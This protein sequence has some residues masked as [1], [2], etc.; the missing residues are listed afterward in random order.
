[1]HVVRILKASKASK[2]S[3]KFK[4][5][6]VKVKYVTD[7]TITKSHLS[8]TNIRLSTEFKTISGPRQNKTTMK[9]PSE[10]QGN[11]ADQPSRK[12]IKGVRKQ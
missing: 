1:M 9:K 8:R 10:K 7:N 12:H 11:N 6:K 2:A 3:E 5:C 4:S